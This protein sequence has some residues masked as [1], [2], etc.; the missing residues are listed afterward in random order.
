MKRLLA[1]LFGLAVLA[2]P[3]FAQTGSQ[4]TTAQ[5]ITEVN[6]NFP[7]QTIGAITPA[8]AR[9]TYLDFL[10][11][12]ASTAGP[13]TSTG[14]QTFTG[15]ILASGAC[16]GQTACIQSI[17]TGNEPAWFSTQSLSGT[18][19]PLTNSF[20]INSDN[21]DASATS[22]LTYWNFAASFGGSNVKGVRDGISL[23]LN[24]VA[25][26]GNTVQQQ[27]NYVAFNPRITAG[28]ADSGP[29]SY[30]TMNPQAFGLTGATNISEMTGAEFDFGLLTGASGPAT[31][32]I[33]AGLALVNQGTQLATITA[34]NTQAPFTGAINTYLWIYNGSTAGI[35][36]AIHFGTPGNAGG[37][38][39]PGGTVIFSEVGSVAN[40]VDVSLLTISGCAF[41]SPG[42]VCIDGS[43]NIATGSVAAILTTTAPPVS[44]TGFLGY[45]FTNV[46][47]FGV[48]PI[49]GAPSFT[50]AKG[51][52]GLDNAGGIPYYN[53]TGATT[54][55]QLVG[56]SAS[57]TLTNKTLTSPTLT[58][59]TTSSGQFVETGTSAPASAAGQA[60]IGGTLTPPTL[61]NTGQAWLYN[62]SAGGG[63]LQGDGSVSDL[64]LLN[65]NGSVI[66]S[67]ATA[68]ATWACGALSTA[69][70]SAIASITATASG[71]LQVGTPTGGDKG[72]GTLNVASTIWTNGT[73]GLASKTC[74][75][76]TTNVA[77]G[78]TLTITNGLI[79][80]TTT[81]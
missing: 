48:F 75:I 26:T 45:L 67:V 7:D 33:L 24:M 19:N 11:S 3:A 65:K 70:T 64:S 15:G 74:T 54:W 58:G 10:A 47:Q 46:S 37:F 5:L 39:T 36:D 21:A 31:S 69:G 80:G 43:G 18:A 12:L 55:V 25:A 23:T 38:P 72:A 60:V 76:N 6:A 61:T 9:Q 29:A 35:T 81:C 73:Q 1:S 22:G 2:A 27:R 53:S 52:I 8:L 28:A 66:C 40:F 13:N 68:S 59:T 63:V 17:P 20:F 4:K 34:S 49:S 62:T 42:A 78:I 79:T 56:L 77:T 57:Q 50:A 30:F 51:S 16:T 41:K 32:K 44:N 14:L 71:G